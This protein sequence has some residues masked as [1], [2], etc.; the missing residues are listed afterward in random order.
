MGLG[1]TAALRS[2]ATEGCLKP[3][4]DKF[5]GAGKTAEEVYDA[6]VVD[7]PA[8]A[9]SKNFGAHEQSAL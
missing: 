2:E 3:P 5:K 6:V 4:L 7:M 8:F 1:M 9:R